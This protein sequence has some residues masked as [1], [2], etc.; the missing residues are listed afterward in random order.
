MWENCVTSEEM[1]NNEHVYYGKTTNLRG[2]IHG[3]LFQSLGSSLTDIGYVFY[4]QWNLL[5]TL[6]SRLFQKNTLITNSTYA[7]YNCNKLT[8]LGYDLYSTCKKLKD[9]SYAFQYCS[10]LRGRS[11]NYLALS[12]VTNKHHCFSGCTNLDNYEDLVDAGWAE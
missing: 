7:F 10:G 5:G 1:V 4:N 12:T 11:F 3:Q 8:G 2:E 6:E 9:L